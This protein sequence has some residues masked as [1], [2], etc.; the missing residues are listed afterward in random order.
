ME[1]S[2]ANKA[3]H[4]I[5]ESFRPGLLTHIWCDKC[6]GFSAIADFKGKVAG[7]ELV[8]CGDCV[9]CGCEITR[10]VPVPAD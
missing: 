6:T 4:K 1:L 10:P 9:N 7:R 3:W 5:P 8:L 2:S